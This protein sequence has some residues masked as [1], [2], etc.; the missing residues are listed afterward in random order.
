[1]YIM[2]K[3]ILITGA[4]G[5]VGSALVEYFIY[6]TE[7]TI[8]YTERSYKSNTRLDN[9]DFKNRVF[10]WNNEN[11]DIILHAAGN[12]SSLDCIKNP[13]SAI[14]DNILETFKMLE[15]A[16]KYKIEH[17]IY[18]SSVEVYGI[19]G[20]CKENS[21]CISMNMYAASKHACEQMCN[22]YFNS[23]GVPCSIVRLNNTFGKMCQEDRFPV[24]AIKK[25]L[26]KEKFIL[27]SNNGEIVGRRWFSIHDVVDMIYF[28]IRQ[29]PGKTYNTTGNYISNLEFLTYIARA[30][31][32]QTFEYDLIEENVP[33]RIGNQDAPPDLIYSLGWKPKKTFNERIQEFVD[34]TI[35][36]LNSF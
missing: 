31:D 11:I 23:Y 35:P 25:L 12:A 22:A 5:F 32:I 4:R 13:E 8:Y 6:N 17:F 26:N 14:N 3:K 30:M 2:V 27:H 34:Y 21:R 1:M 10:V 29:P 19:E 16:R 9:M 20:L 15:I 7:Y 24:L 33:G 28:I 18:I 36:T